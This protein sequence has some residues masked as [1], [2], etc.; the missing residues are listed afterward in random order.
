MACQ[1]GAR[2][3]YLSKDPLD[4]NCPE[5]SGSGSRAAI[6]RDSDGYAALATINESCHCSRSIRLALGVPFLI[7]ALLIMI[8]MDV[9][10]MTGDLS[11]SGLWL[12]ETFP[13]LP[14]MG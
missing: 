9:A 8:A 14:R 11:T 5:V 3:D 13:V 2:P 6:Q 10:V 12:L 1:S 7:A 4:W